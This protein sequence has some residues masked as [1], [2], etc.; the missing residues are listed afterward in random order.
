MECTRVSTSGSS[1]ASRI[2]LVRDTLFQLFNLETSLNGTPPEQVQLDIRAIRKG[3]ATLM[4]LEAAWGVARRT[5]SRA[6]ASPTGDLLLY[7]I[8]EGGSWHQN[9]R[10]EQFLTRTGSVVLSSQ[11]SPCTV[12]APA[13]R[14]WRFRSLRVLSSSMPA[15]GDCIRRRGLSVLREDTAVAQLFQQYMAALLER[16]EQL[17]PRDVADAVVALDALLAASLGDERACVDDGGR[18]LRAARLVRARGFIERSLRNPQLGPDLVAAH[19]GVSP[20]QAHRLFELEG[21]SISVEI[22]R[23]RVSEAQAL[24]A[25][26]AS[27]SV[28][29]IAFA[30]GFDS[31]ATFY[32]CFRAETGMTASEWRARA[33]T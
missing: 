9:E 17:D 6:S 23:L 20:R 10:G 31:L 18:A 24:L 1:G 32:R 15:S 7:Q 30:C 33:F 12:A 11:V 25:R 13:G 5:A 22:R 28:T 29:D 4:D 27:R 26:D 3:P 16:F 21:T 2:A 14:P 19:I 8:H